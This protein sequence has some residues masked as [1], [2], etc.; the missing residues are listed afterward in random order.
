M[1]M[2]KPFPV[3]TEEERSPAAERIAEI[4][5]EIIAM[6]EAA[7]NPPPYVAPPVH[8]LIAENTRL[9]MEAGAARVKLVQEERA[10]ALIP[11][12][13]FKPESTPVHRPKDYVPNMKQGHTNARTIKG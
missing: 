13:P 10:K 2:G 3:A 5:A 11:Q 4:H 12:D 1:P 9:E 6:R 8:P 7:A